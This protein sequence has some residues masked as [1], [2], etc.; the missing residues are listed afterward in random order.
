VVCQWIGNSQKV[1]AKH[2]LQ[3]TDE[4]FTAAAGAPKAAQ[5][6]A[7]LGCIEP[8]G[9]EPNQENPEETQLCSASAGSEW[10]AQDSNL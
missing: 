1:A 10:A 7:E 4:H 8:H 3:V 2:Y 9:A 5:N 6:G